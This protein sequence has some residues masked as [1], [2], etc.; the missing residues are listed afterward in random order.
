MSG[1]SVSSSRSALPAVG[2]DDRVEPANGEVRADQVDDV[3]IVLDRAARGWLAAGSGIAAVS[4]RSASVG[5][6]RRRAA[7][8]ARPRRPRAG[9][10]V[11]AR[12]SER[13]DRQRIRNVVPSAPAQLD[14]APVRVHD[15]AR[16]RQPQA[17]AGAARSRASRVAS[18]GDRASSPREAATVVETIDL[19]APAARASRVVSSRAATDTRGFPWVVA[20]R[21]GEQVHE[22]LLEAIVVGPDR[23]QLGV[24][25]D[26]HARRTRAAGRQSTAASSTSREIAPVGL[27]SHHPGLD[28]REVQQ[29]VDEPAEPRGLGGDPLEEALLGLAVP[30]HVGRHQARGI[31]ADRR[32][33]RAQLVAQPRQEPSL[34]LPRAPQRGR[35]LVGDPAS[36]RSSASRSECAAFSISAVSCSVTAELRPARQQRGRPG[37]RVERNDQDPLRRS[38][39]E[40]RAR[41]RRGAPRARVAAA[42]NSSDIRAL[43]SVPWGPAYARQ[44][45]SPVGLAREQADLVGT[46]A[47]GAATAAR[48]RS[49]S[50][51]V[52]GPASVSSISRIV[53]STRLRAVTWSQ[54]P[55]ALDRARGVAGV[56][57]SAGRAR[58]RPGSPGVGHERG[59]HGADPGGAH[60]RHRPRRRRSA[61][62]SLAQ[63]PASRRV[64]MRRRRPARSSRGGTPGRPAAAP[65]GRRDQAAICRLVNPSAAAHASAPPLAT[66]MHAARTPSAEPSADRISDRLDDGSAEISRS[67]SPCSRVSWRRAEESTCWP[68]CSA[69]RSSGWLRARVELADDLAVAQDDDP[70]REP[71][72]LLG[73]AADE[74][75]RRAPRRSARSAPRHAPLDRAERRR[76]LVEHEQPRLRLIAPGD[77]TADAGRRTAS[78]RAASCPG[79]GSAGARARR[80][81]RRGSAS[82]RASAAASRRPAAGCRRRRGCR[83]AP[84][85]ARRPRRP[86]AAPRPG[87]RGSG[88]RRPRSRR[89]SGAMSPAMQRT[90]V[91][92]PAPGSPASAT[93]S[94]AP[95]SSSTSRSAVRAPNRTVIPAMCSIGAARSG[96]PLPARRPRR[97]PAST[98]A[99]RSL[100]SVATG[101]RYPVAI[102]GLDP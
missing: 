50:A 29:V 12:A 2:G 64:R 70:V 18:N 16:D 69:A 91:V 101:R 74:Q 58:S 47:P 62:R 71:E 97:R 99:R 60:H 25:G 23:R 83:T 30:G 3:R 10:S 95:T 42:S 66:W 8:A 1:S 43:R 15:A 45:I 24:A 80:R 51:T 88:R 59:D 75:D 100:R 65:T 9:A 96:G 39:A 67:A 61:A 86:G 72:H 57:R 55:V 44:T 82:P 4:R 11:A 20:E 73:V 7:P 79:S 46:A 85:P 37:R 87:R 63:R 22:H 40:L 14:R 48:V 31:A 89:P 17:G 78:R 52:T 81:P 34:E 19:D 28:R 98:P 13:L 49:P 94:P 54:Q 84:G 6:R 68:D 56:Q 41:S 77:R 32:Q 5:I 21:V 92:L 53:S 33:R 90:S 38:A 27:E 35:L 36:S 93:S 26:R 102:P 76:R